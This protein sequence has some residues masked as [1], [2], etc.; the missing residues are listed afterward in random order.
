MLRSKLKWLSMIALVGAAALAGTAAAQTGNTPPPGGDGTGTV[1]F[2]K[3]QQ[4]TPQQEVVEAD[5]Q[6]GRMEQAATTVR[7][8]LEQARAARDVVKTLCLNDKLSQI[9]VAIRSA[10][11][12]R[13]SLQLAAGRNDTEMSNH[14]YTILTVLRQRT[15]QLTAE[16][17]Q[18]IGEEAVLIGESK[19]TTS[20]DPTL[21]DDPD[22]VT[23]PY[24][25]GV[26]SLPPSCVS[27]SR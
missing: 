9:D 24:D 19:I 2:Q 23:N 22:T 5:S 18:C 26:I 12:R 11:D 8:Q 15:E 20:I 16:A 6:I 25:P 7:K 4:L 17:N 14:E 27:C 21:P 13:T 3:K 10:K 1:G